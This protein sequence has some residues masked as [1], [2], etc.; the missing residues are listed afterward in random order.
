MT[1]VA[2]LLFEDFIGPINGARFLSVFGQ[3]DSLLF[4]NQAKDAPCFEIGHCCNGN[5][6]KWANQQ[7]QNEPTHPAHPFVAALKA[8]SQ[9][10]FPASVA[11]RKWRYIHTIGEALTTMTPGR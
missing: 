6:R 11:T 5:K 4:S 8:A 7:G 10:S 1:S 2:P 3:A 9:L